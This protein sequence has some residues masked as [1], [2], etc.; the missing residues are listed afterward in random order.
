MPRLWLVAAALASSLGWAPIAGAAPLSA[1]LDVDRAP[2]AESCPDADAL[3]KQV[4]ALAGAPILSPQT[5]ADLA[6]RVRIVPKDRG[7]RAEVFASGARNGERALEDSGPGCEG[8]GR[9]LVVI[10]ALLLDAPLEPRPPAS[11]R[12]CSTSTT[13][14]A[15]C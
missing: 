4:E 1:K 10:L 13:C 12:C 5:P 2:G 6:V 3:K 15:T 8:L 9:G 7:F 11:T 14:P